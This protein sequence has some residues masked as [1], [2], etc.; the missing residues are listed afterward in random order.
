MFRCSGVQVFRVLVFG[1]LGFL[2]KLVFDE[3]GF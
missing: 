1:S 2:M 3:S